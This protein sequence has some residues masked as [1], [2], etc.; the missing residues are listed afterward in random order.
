MPYHTLIAPRLLAVAAALAFAGSGV[1]AGEINSNLQI[2]AG[3]TFL[4][5]GGQKGTLQVRGRNVGPVAV[6]VL[7]QVEG[8]APVLRGTVQPGGDLTAR[9]GANETALLRNTSDTKM[10]RLKLVVSGDTSGLGMTYTAN[11]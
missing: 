3:Q 5:G 7:G 4:L 9:F 11:P 1:S 6:I 8:A 2:E 10:A